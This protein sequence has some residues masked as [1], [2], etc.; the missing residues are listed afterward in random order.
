M[1]F[2]KLKGTRD[3]IYDEAA[4]K[5]HL[6][7][8]FRRIATGYGFSE[9]IT[10]IL[11]Y[12]EL[13]ERSTGATTDIVQKEMYAFSDKGGRSITLRPEGTPGVVRAIL[14][15]KIKFP[16]RLF[17]IGPMFRYERPQKGRL[18]EFY[19]LGVE[20]LGEANPKVDLELIEL[21]FELFSELGIK[22][23]L[24]INSVGCPKCRPFYKERLLDF[25][26]GKNKNLCVDCRIRLERNPL[27]V[28]DCKNESCQNILETAPKI[29]DFLCSDCQ[30]HFA[31]VIKGLKKLEDVSLNI[32]DRLVRGIDYYTK[33]AYEFVSKELGAQNSLGGGGRYDDLVEEF[34]GPKTP[35]T[36]FALG[37]ERILLL[38]RNTEGGGRNLVFIAFL[39]ES[40]QRSAESLIKV[41]RKNGIPSLMSYSKEKLTSQLKKADQLHSRW[42]IIIG[43]DELKKGVYTLRDM[44]SGEQKLVAEQELVSYIKQLK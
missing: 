8:E 26:K 31:E 25:F 11:E 29:K 28:F 12:T 36:G 10:P 33:T 13:F 7:N 14:E 34:G 17:Y 1:R 40:A 32:N 9:I 39:D 6:E 21:G 43:E 42:T 38:M 19:Q 37:E 16:C 5:L 2:T 22:S 15:N 27:R 20:V 24:E 23:S 18:R 30:T 4:K 41:L 35:A 3:I 44:E